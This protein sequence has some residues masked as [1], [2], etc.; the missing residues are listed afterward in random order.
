MNDGTITITRV[1]NGWVV[2][3]KEVCPTRD[4]EKI[5]VFTAGEWPKCKA[6]LSELLL[7]EEPT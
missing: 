1:E 2:S 4:T 3:V 6:Y 7:D 5:H